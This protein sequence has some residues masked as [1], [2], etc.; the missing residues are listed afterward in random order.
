MKNE[1][2]PYHHLFRVLHGVLAVSMVVLIVTGVGLHAVAR[3]GWSLLGQFQ[4]WIP[5]GRLLFSHMVASLFFTLSMIISTVLFMKRFQPKN[6]H[7]KQIRWVVN[8]LL[9]V[10]SLLTI[11]TSFGLLYNVSASAYEVNR[12]LHAIAG[13]VL[14]PLALITH[15]VLAVT[16]HAKMLPFVF[17][18]LRQAR[19]VSFIWLPVVAII[20]AAVLLQFPAK[21]IGNRVLTAEKTPF[22]PENVEAL[23]TLDWPVSE[24]LN[25]ELYKGVGLSSGATTIVHRAK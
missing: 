20:S 9:V 8:Y 12:L 24:P 22:S 4:S 23:R 15:A 16:K 18:P 10:A 25:I 19:W 11:I 7:F 3:P 1:K 2:T 17:L 14:L 13:L 5:A 6:H 21:A